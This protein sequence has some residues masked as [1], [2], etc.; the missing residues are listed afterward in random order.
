MK[1]T[2]AILL[3]CALAGCVT[4]PMDVT[5]AGRD[6]II[7]QTLR[8]ADVRIGLKLA[9]LEDPLKQLGST[10]NIQSGKIFRQV[11]TGGDDAPA[12]IDIVHSS[13]SQQ[14]VDQMIVWSSQQVIYTATVEFRHNGQ[15]RTLHASAPGKTSFSTDRA[16]RE[17][18]EK[19]V[20]D[21]AKQAQIFMRPAAK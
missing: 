9:T 21:I 6:T 1:I 11:F 17:A 2:P 15:T 8:L 3:A 10:F 16:A 18:I 19:V 7:P 20:I 13:I 4:A 14:T 12:F 5:T